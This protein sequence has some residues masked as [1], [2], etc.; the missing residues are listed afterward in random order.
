M[1]TEIFQRQENEVKECRLKTVNEVRAS[2]FLAGEG[3]RISS[4]AA[5]SPFNQKTQSAVKQL[6]GRG[7][8]VLLKIFWKYL[9]NLQYCIMFWTVQLSCAVMSNVIMCIISNKMVCWVSQQD[10]FDFSVLCSQLISFTLAY[11]LF[12]SHVSYVIH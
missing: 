2:N 1:F 12:V 10:I 11:N 9:P 7:A 6:Y 4:Y 5:W 8:S 3:G